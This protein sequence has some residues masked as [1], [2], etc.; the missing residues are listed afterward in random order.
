MKLAIVSAMHSELVFLLEKVTLIK[1]EKKG[2]YTFYETTYKHHE[3]ILVES[4]IG[5]V[6]AGFLMGV[7][8]SEYPSI[9]AVINIGVAGGMPHKTHTADVVL[10]EHTAFIDADMT[11]WN[12]PHG[13]IQGIPFPLVADEQLLKLALQV[14]G[15]H[16]GDIL[17]GDTFFIK[18]DSIQEEI[19]KDYAFLNVCALDMESAAFHEAAFLGK[20]PFLAV[21]AISDVLGEEAQVDAY[22]ST[23][24]RAVKASTDFLLEFINLL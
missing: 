15:A 19:N 13:E 1:E 6:A 21:R 3:M 10:G 9:E 11:A 8:L 23:L 2:P 17:T 7:L 20:K 24:D 14:K 12:L 4:G 5:K 16:C 22:N 18:L